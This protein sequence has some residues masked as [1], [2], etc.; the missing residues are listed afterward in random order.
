MVVPYSLPGYRANS[1]HIP[2][3]IPLKEIHASTPRASIMHAFSSICNCQH[4]DG[5]GPSNQL[6]NLI[7]SLDP[8]H[9]VFGIRPTGQT[10]DEDPGEP[11]DKL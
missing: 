5:W 10:N 8:T 11:S 6:I 1:Y 2:A 3:Y 4:W 9:I 7:D